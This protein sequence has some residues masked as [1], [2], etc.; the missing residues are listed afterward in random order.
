MTT[1]SGVI[2][3]ASSKDSFGVGGRVIESEK[4][5]GFNTSTENLYKAR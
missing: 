4:K 3:K 1:D 2:K 5:I